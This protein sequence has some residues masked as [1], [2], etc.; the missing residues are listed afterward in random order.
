MNIF[1]ILEILTEVYNG[2]TEVIKT[3]DTIRIYNDYQD[4]GTITITPNTNISR[5]FRTW[6]F[7]T[8]RDNTTDDPRIRSPY[9]KIDLTFSN[10]SNYKLIMHNLITNYRLSKMMY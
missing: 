4:T 1:D 9:I 3:F 5:R 10:S 6:K 2:S 7:N 8:I